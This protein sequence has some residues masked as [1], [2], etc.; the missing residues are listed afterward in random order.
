M[1]RLNYNFLM[2][3]DYFF[4]LGHLHN[5]RIQINKFTFYLLKEK[6]KSIK[7]LKSTPTKK[8]SGKENE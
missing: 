7:S 4:Q 1:F 2:V 3:D 8:H 6:K 5:L